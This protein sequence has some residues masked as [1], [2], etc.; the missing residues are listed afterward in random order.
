MVQKEKLMLSVEQE[1]LR[2]H[3]HAARELANQPLPFSACT[4]LKDKE[5]YSM[6]KKE[7]E[8]TNKTSRYNGRLFISWAQE[9][10]DK[11]DKIM[12][13]NKTLKAN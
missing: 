13:R 6:P 7:N 10:D 8:N 2:V 11:W 4:F 5:V 1:I 3:G 12:V 9:M